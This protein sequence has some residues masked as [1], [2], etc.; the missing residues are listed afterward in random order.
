MSVRQSLTTAAWGREN[1]I[2]LTGGDTV[3]DGGKTSW[4]SGAYGWIHDMTTF[5]CTHL[6]CSS[7]KFKTWQIRTYFTEL[8]IKSNT[9]MKYLAPG[10]ILLTSM[11]ITVRYWLGEM[12]FM[13]LLRCAVSSQ[14]LNK[15]FTFLPW[16]DDGLDL[17]NFINYWHHLCRIN[18]S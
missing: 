16:T 3:Q 15:P 5:R 17:T 2:L 9:A 4:A 1:G 12:V 13:I 6:H 11:M 10:R 18:K 7:A 14:L 8:S